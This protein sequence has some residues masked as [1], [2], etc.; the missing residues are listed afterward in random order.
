VKDVQVKVTRRHTYEPYSWREV[1][2]TATLEPGEARPPALERLHD[3]VAA[4]LNLPTLREE[5]AAALLDK[6]DE[7]WRKQHGEAKDARYH[8]RE[9]CAS[10]TAVRDPQSDEAARRRHQVRARDMLG[11]AAQHSDAADTL[12]QEMELQEQDEA[13]RAARQ[14]LR[15][16]RPTDPELAG[17]GE[18]IQA[19]QAELR[20]VSGSCDPGPAG[21]ALALPSEDDLGDFDDDD[22]DDDFDDDFDDEV[23]A[24]NRVGG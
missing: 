22:D 3:E 14:L 6:V 17:K 20:K 11:K 24:L 9:A 7:G 5:R 2:A 23:E 15:R 10:L 4:V 8:A 12:A 1:T 19:L 18:D 16:P 13:V 21:P